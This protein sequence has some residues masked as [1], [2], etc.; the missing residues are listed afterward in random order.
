M[1]L[2]EVKK[3]AMPIISLKKAEEVLMMKKAALLGV[4]LM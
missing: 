3:Q 2:L 1:V 4:V